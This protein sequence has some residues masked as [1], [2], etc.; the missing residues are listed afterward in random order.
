MGGKM[1]PIRQ[2]TE[3]NEAAARDENKYCKNDQKKIITVNVN[4]NWGAQDK[5]NNQKNQSYRKRT[6]IMMS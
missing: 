2:E 1:V 6:N 5:I 4:V 3:A